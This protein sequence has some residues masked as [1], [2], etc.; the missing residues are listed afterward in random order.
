MSELTRRWQQW[1]NLFNA[2]SLR[3]RAL[4]TVGIVAVIVLLL[5]TLLLQPLDVRQK[6]LSAQLSEAR[7]AIK[8]GEILST[9]SRLAL[10]DREQPPQRCA[11][12]TGSD[13]ANRLF[14]AP[15]GRYE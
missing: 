1:T 3:E 13:P 2:R 14:G 10:C 12:R 7:T 9:V 5:D 15:P 4:I 11:S 6:R 8:A